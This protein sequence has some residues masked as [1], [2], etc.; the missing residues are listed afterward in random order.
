MIQGVIT[1][2]QIRQAVV[3]DANNVATVIEAAVVG[4]LVRDQISL[5]RAEEESRDPFIT[6]EEPQAFLDFRY[7]NIRHKMLEVVISPIIFILR[8]WWR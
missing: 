4:K 5:A 1:G 6:M 8:A 3:E 2:K 7:G